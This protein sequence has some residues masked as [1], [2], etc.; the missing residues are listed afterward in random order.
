MKI[1]LVNPPNRND[2]YYDCSYEFIHLGLGYIASALEK[3]GHDVDIYECGINHIK[4]EQMGMYL[5]DLGYEAIGFTTYY[6]N[7]MQVYRISM[8]IK[9]RKNCFIFVGGIFASMNYKYI[10]ENP[11]IDCC[12]LGEGEEVVVELMNRLQE[13]EEIESLAGIV[14][15]K[16]GKLL[17]TKKRDC[18]HNLDS[19]EIPKR[20]FLFKGKIASMIASRGC[21]GNCSFCGIIDYYKTYA[22]RNIRIRSPQN[23]I[24]EIEY[25]VDNFGAQYIYFQ[26]ENLLSILYK[27]PDWIDKF[28]DEII[29]RGLKF[30]FYMYARADDII[31]SKE[32]IKLLIEVGLDCIFIGIESFVERQLQLYEKRIKS[33]V[34]IKTLDFVR[35]EKLKLNMGFILFDPY[36]TIEELKNNIIRLLNVEFYNLCYWGQTPI[37]LLSPLYPMPGTRFEKKLIDSGLYDG[38][39]F[40]KYRFINDDVQ[41]IYDKLDQWRNVVKKKYIELD[42]HYKAVI[43]G[44]RKEDK[45]CTSKLRTLLRI[46]IEFLNELINS[47][48]RD[49]N[50]WMYINKKYEKRIGDI[51]V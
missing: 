5:Y 7:I 15:K 31:K 39:I 6:Y 35:S 23:V 25:L 9:K 20:V 34:N 41:Y 14:L 50:E 29:E 38:S 17:V 8:H 24:N 4:S 11:Y 12:V 47:H 13:E 49:E 2:V 32:K 3:K 16:D 1:A 37:S 19:L 18:I 10:M 28:H 40:H 42:L 30:N 51:N 33:E 21:N 22:T 27:D 36:I 43:F 46:D 48:F 26:D 44:D 45:I